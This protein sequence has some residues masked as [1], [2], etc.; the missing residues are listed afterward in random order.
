MGQIPEYGPNKVRD[1]P[2]PSPQQSASA[3]PASFGA[4]TSQFLGGVG[5][6]LSNLGDVFKAEEDAKSR[7]LVRDSLNT[8]RNE[9]RGAMSEVY[10]KKGRDAVDV[11]PGAEKTM[12]EIR[13]KHLQ[14]FSTEKQKALFTATYD[15]VSSGHLDRADAFERKSR[16]DFEIETLDA[17]NQNA[18]NDA[19]S[20][21]TD[22][23]LIAMSDAEITANTRAKYKSFGADIQ[24]Q[25]VA[26]G[27]QALHGSIVEAIQNDSP[28]AAQAYLKE[29]KDKFN[30]TYAA[31]KGKEVDDQ[32]DQILVQDKAKEISRSS[33]S[34]DDQLAEVDKI[35]DPV[36]STK[37]RALVKQRY[38]EKQKVKEAASKEVRNV[39]GDKIYRSPFTY[40]LDVA[41][42]DQET[43]D[44]LHTLQVRVR[45]DE[46]AKQGAGKATK[47]NPDV[48]MDL[49]AKSVED[50]RE[51]DMKDYV[52]QLSTSH[53]KEL[54][55]R[56]TK[57]DIR[58]N[59][60]QTLK[61]AISGMD[62]FNVKEEGDEASKRKSQLIAAFENRINAIP[63]NEQT[64]DKINDIL[65]KD[66]LAPIQIGFDDFIPFNQRT[67]YSF[68]VQAL[69]VKEKKKAIRAMLPDNI[70]ANSHIEFADGVFYVYGDGIRAV[71]DREG[72]LLKRQVLR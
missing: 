24:K 9:M 11:Y 65:Y 66:L 67:Y 51:E 35:K 37:V 28:E 27:R 21:Y 10:R 68:E 7:S 48:Y 54:Q 64:P 12:N 8:A 36:V 3:S 32:V 15:A 25:K 52:N 2:L 19:V 13:K 44:Y 49:R 70:D 47:S 17:E 23:N 38:E 45:K 50:L 22:K 16:E 55:D 59:Y 46:L 39:E 18:I 41:K 62:D 53:L 40:E 33:V 63:P 56:Q 26:E 43:Q 6:A 34:L 30:P 60:M 58:T 57:G 20:A 61:T 69:D 31:A 72:N 1:T 14:S 29:N 71:Y 5:S 42:H 4:S